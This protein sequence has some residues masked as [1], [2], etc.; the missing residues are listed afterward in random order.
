MSPSSPRVSPAVS[1]AL[2]VL[3][4]LAAPLPAQQQAQ[5]HQDALGN[6]TFALAGDAIITRKLSVYSEPE[7]LEIRDVLRGAT[8]A[9]VNAEM[10]FLDYDEPEVIPASQSGGTYMRAEPEL[11]RELTWMGID[12]VSTAN[13]HSLDYSYGGLRA[14]LKWLREAG[15]VAA[16]TGENLA[17]ARAPHYLDTPGGRVALVSVASTFA[18]FNPAGPQRKD[19]RGRPG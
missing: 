19:M 6:I 16:G 14:N 2:T 17:A 11:A 8:A 5:P 1:L 4:V 9:Y 10:L 15:L 18:D 12:L 3:A 7:F 13:N